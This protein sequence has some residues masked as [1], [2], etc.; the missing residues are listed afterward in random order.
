MQIELEIMEEAISLIKSYP[1]DRTVIKKQS[2]II[3]RCLKEIND[4]CQSKT[5]C[6]WC[7]EERG[8][9]DAYYYHAS[10]Q[11]AILNGAGM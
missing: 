6:N 7:N 5:V 10:C 3:R 8:K 2:E 11:E 4:D 1:K 9:L